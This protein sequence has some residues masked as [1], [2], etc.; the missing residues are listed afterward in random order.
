M[1]FQMTRLFLIQ[2]SSFLFQQLVYSLPALPELD[3][4]C[5]LLF[6][7]ARQRLLWEV[8]LL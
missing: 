3:R 4:M 2:Y 6:D 7:Q 8:Q 1:R 5:L